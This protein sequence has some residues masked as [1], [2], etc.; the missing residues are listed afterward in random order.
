MRETGRFVNEGFGWECKR[1]RERGGAGG[2]ARG[3]GRPGEAAA[4]P[5]FFREGEAEGGGPH[6]AS[7]ALARWTD[8][9]RATLRCPACGVEEEFRS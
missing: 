5:R 9:S 4:L 6:L 2:A 1:C 3:V 7:G 8:E